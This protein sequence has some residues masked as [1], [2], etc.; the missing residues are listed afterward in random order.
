MGGQRY[1][2]Q[3]RH[4]SGYK[5]CSKS[6]TCDELCSFKDIPTA[7]IA[8]IHLGAIGAVVRSTSLLASIKQKYS[9]SHIT[10]ITQKPCDSLLQS[11]PQL[12]MVLT[13]SSE[14]I[15]KASNFLYDLVI[16]VDKSL[17]AT[18]IAGQLRT[19][20]LVGFT[21]DQRGGIIPAN[22]AAKELWELG[23]DN[24]AKF[25]VNQKPETQLMCEAFELPYAR[26]DYNLPMTTDESRL[27]KAKRESWALTGNEIFVGINTGCSPVIPYKKLSFEAYVELIERIKKHNLVPVLLGGPEDQDR[28]EKLHIKTGAIFTSCHRGL[29]DGL[30]SVAACDI[31]LTGD[32]LGMHMAISQK[33]WVVA[34]FGPTCAHEIDLYDRGEKIVTEASCSPCW[35]RQCS[36]STMC[37]DLVSL[38][39]LIQAILNGKDNVL[40]SM[41]DSAIS[42]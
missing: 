5:P 27:S 34:W 17:V 39:K 40:K 14:D 41:P 9:S 38:D 20:K 18:G 21:A 24:H 10:W 26:Q 7:R 16:C 22:F 33:K 30:T 15:L 31:V 42:I 37:Y 25:F 2:I 4:F 35:K 13:T 28:N 29:R 6:Q 3:C 8:L 19:K 1:Q 36:K 23:L 32:S 11:H 12:D